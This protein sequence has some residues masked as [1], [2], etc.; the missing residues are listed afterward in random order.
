MSL[1]NDVKQWLPLESNPVSLNTY[2]KT[3]GFQTSE[4]QFVDVL[5]TEQWA[6]DMIPQPVLAILFL[7]PMKKQKR[8][9]PTKIE[10]RRT[11]KQILCQD[12]WYMKQRIRN[13]CGTF[14]ILHALA[15]LPSSIQAQEKLFQ[16]STWIERFLKECSSLDDHND[17][18][19]LERAKLL[20]SN[21]E[22]ETLHDASAKNCDNQTRRGSV[23]DTV[24][25]HFIAFVNKNNQLYELDGRSECGPILHRQTDQEHF[26]KHTCEIIQN[27]FM[28]LDPEEIRFSILA[29]APTKT[30]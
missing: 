28:N 1:T 13:A 4:Y 19:P 25:I 2:I 21:N 27:D 10:T 3:L 5:S 16:S 26:L 6:I 15:N 20:E 12:V 30:L 29:L 7:F 23:N 18:L 14:A 22:I 24:D 8:S 9:S 11:N 17:N